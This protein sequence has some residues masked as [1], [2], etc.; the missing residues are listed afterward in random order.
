MTTEDE[1]NMN[2]YDEEP[3]LPQFAEVLDE[4]ADD[5]DMNVEEQEEGEIGAESSHIP[6]YADD[7]EDLEDD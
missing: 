4:D 3:D 5:A 6:M 1:L 2:Q 7:E